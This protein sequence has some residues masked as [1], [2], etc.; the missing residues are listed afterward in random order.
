MKKEETY[1]FRNTRWGMSRSDVL[2]SEPDKP[3]VQTDRQ[4][5]YFTTILDKNIYL[6]FVFKTIAWFQRCMP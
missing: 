4:I 3:I 6:A 2:A 1:D 5:G